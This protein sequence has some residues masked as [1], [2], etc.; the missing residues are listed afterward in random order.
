MAKIIIIENNDL[1]LT[2]TF[3]YNKIL[4]NFKKVKFINYLKRYTL[5]Y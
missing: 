1:S 4:T 5:V 3:I 2:Y